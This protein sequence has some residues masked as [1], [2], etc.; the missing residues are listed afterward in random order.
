MDNLTSGKNVIKAFCE[1][2]PLDA[3]VAAPGGQELAYAR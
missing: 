1:I 3:P 2:A